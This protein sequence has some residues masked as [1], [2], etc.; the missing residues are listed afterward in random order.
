M[1][2][3][4]FSTNCGV[5]IVALGGCLGSGPRARAEV[6]ALEEPPPTRTKE[7]IAASI[8]AEVNKIHPNAG[9][10]NISPKQKSME[11]QSVV[12]VTKPYKSADGEVFRCISPYDP[13][14]INTGGGLSCYN[15]DNP[16]VCKNCDY[17]CKKLG[18]IIPNTGGDAGEITKECLGNSYAVCAASTNSTSFNGSEIPMGYRMN[19]VDGTVQPHTGT[20]FVRSV[21]PVM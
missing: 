4:K 10:T 6:P 18:E 16:T 5:F 8:G 13:S 17:V 9:A 20:G 1:G 14:C 12:D 3:N 21:P 19:G 15:G 7:Q 2:K 11:A